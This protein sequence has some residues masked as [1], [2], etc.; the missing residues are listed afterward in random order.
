MHDLGYLH[1]RFDGFLIIRVPCKNMWVESKLIPESLNPIWEGFGL[2][3]SPTYTFILFQD[4]HCHP[5]YGNNQW[6]K[7]Q[8]V[9]LKSLNN[10]LKIK[11]LRSRKNLSLLKE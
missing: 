4:V 9:M 10:Y 7:E 11:L 2:A 8:S 6:T 5:L 1:L 3:S